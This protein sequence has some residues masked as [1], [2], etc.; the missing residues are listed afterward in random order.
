MSTSQKARGRC[1]NGFWQR[2]GEKKIFRAARTASG[3]ER[4]R[5]LLPSE[6]DVWKRKSRSKDEIWVVFGAKLD[7][8]KLLRGRSLEADVYQPEGPWEVRER[9]LAETRRREYF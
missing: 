2:R 4:R 9:L 1:E 8:G 5:V 6:S 3:R 7:Y